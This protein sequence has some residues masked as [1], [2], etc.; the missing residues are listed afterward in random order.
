MIE[1]VGDTLLDKDVE[2][3]LLNDT[4]P[5][6]D[7]VGLDVNDTVLV[8]LLDSDTEYD[9]DCVFELLMVGLRDGVIVM[10][11]EPV[12]DGDEVCELVGVTDGELEGGGEAL[13]E[14]PQN[15]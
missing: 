12:D 5:V 6:D 2:H 8:P 3:V 10:L 7:G 9:D 1:L 15:T 13:K 14:Y 11:I 4:L